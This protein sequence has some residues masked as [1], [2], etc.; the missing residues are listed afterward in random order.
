MDN[1]GKNL[2]FTLKLY[3]LQHKLCDQL[4]LEL[5]RQ[6]LRRLDKSLSSFGVKPV[7]SSRLSRSDHG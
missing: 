4:G 2:V 7:M 3:P 1:V 6:E 5:G